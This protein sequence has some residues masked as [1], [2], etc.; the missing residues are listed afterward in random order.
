MPPRLLTAAGSSH[1]RRRTGPR[2]GQLKGDQQGHARGNPAA[3]TIANSSSNGW[4][5][6]A[7]A[8]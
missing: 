4:A 7:A 2:Y 1:H 3:G 6:V 5:I 8:A